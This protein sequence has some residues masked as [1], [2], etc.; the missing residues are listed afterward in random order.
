MRVMRNNVRW[1]QH[2][3]TESV[4]NWNGHLLFAD[5]DG[6]IRASGVLLPLSTQIEHE[7]FVRVGNASLQVAAS[8]ILVRF[9]DSVP[10]D[11]VLEQALPAA[12]QG[13]DLLTALAGPVG[14]VRLGSLPSLVWWTDDASRVARLNADYGLALRMR[15][16]GEVRVLD[17]E[18]NVVPQ[19]VPSVPLL[20]EGLRYFR[21][22]QCTDDLFDAF[23]NGYLALEATLADIRPKATGE[24]EGTWLKSALAQAQGTVADLGIELGC[25]AAEVPLRFHD[26]IY[27]NVRCPLFHG[28]AM[29]LDPG[30][31]ADRDLVQQAY[32]KVIRSYLA[33]ARKRYHMRPRGGG[34]FTPEGFAGLNHTMDDWTIMFGEGEHDGSHSSLF[35]LQ[36]SSL[37]PQPN[38]VRRLGVLSAPFK[39]EIDLVNFIAAVKD[40]QVAFWNS[41]D[42]HLYLDSLDRFEVLIELWNDVDSGYRTAFAS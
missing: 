5:P 3:G 16:S 34:G 6:T 36:S 10:P 25:A 17:A 13:L 42:G 15:M 35:G 41:F 21:L 27:K 9:E 32:Q 2:D 37:A 26:D 4:A 39:D 20:H 18:G 22:S 28:K 29:G 19:P 38:R 33:L 8:H 23:R 14:T 30:S 12:A 31:P 1:T 11:S 24:R 7:G 40:E